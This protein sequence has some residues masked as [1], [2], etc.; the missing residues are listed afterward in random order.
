MKKKPVG[1]KESLSKAL[2]MQGMPVTE[3][4][5]ETVEGSE[6]EITEEN[7]TPKKKFKLKGQTKKKSKDEFIAEDYLTAGYP[8]NITGGS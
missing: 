2:K 8:S 4:E 7:S 5:F 6:E 3:G 1:R